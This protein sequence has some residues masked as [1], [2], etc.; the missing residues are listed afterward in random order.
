MN[1]VNEK[2][3]CFRKNTFTNS[4]EKGTVYGMHSQ[5]IQVTFSLFAI[6]LL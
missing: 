5:H 6:S 3:Y 4:V 1:A 2:L